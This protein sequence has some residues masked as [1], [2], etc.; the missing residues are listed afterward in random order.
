MAVA[1]L[2]IALP[3]RPM[4]NICLLP[5]GERQ[6]FDPA[7]DMNSNLGKVVR[8]F[9]DGTV[10]TDNPFYDAANPVTSQIWSL[11]HR[12][13]L[14]LAFDNKGQLWNQEMGPRARR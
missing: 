6:K 3:F 7:Q 2:A 12:N 9:P 1:I 8:L 10:P 4:A 5:S 11:G 13:P 14:G